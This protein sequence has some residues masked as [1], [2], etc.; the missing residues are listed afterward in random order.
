MKKPEMSIVRFSSE[1]IIATSPETLLPGMSAGA[2]QATGSNQIL[3]GS[4]VIYASM[5]MY[6][7]PANS[8]DGVVNNNE[9]GE[10]LTPGLYYHYSNLDEWGFA[11]GWQTCNDETHRSNGN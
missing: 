9:N 5:P 6:G 1:D 10:V 3:V 2:Y 7:D 11:S 4:K 8:V